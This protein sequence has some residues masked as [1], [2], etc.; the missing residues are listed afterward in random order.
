MPTRRLKWLARKRRAA[1]QLSWAHS[2]PKNT[3]TLPAHYRAA[4]DLLAETEPTYVVALRS[5][6]HHRLLARGLGVSATLLAAGA[7]FT[8]LPENISRW[9]TAGIAGLAAVVSGIMT[10]LDPVRES[11]SQRARAVTCLSLRYDVQDYLRWLNSLDDA[12]AH[13]AQA[14]RVLRG[15]QEKQVAI[16]TMQ[17]ARLSGSAAGEASGHEPVHADTGLAT[18]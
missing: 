6:D 10:G 12:K 17:V 7:G 14:N 9:V 18:E 13:Q 3:S 1:P 2:V 15:L 11:N 5:A 4:V 8:A 16:F